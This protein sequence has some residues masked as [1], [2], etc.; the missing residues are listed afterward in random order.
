MNKTDIRRIKKAFKGSTQG[1]WNIRRHPQIG[2]FVERPKQSGEAYGVEILGE[3]DY[4]TKE[5]DMEFVVLAHKFMPEAL[6]II[7]ELVKACELAYI[8]L[9]N[10]NARLASKTLKNA[11]ANAENK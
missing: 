9:N 5:G 11:I 2:T 4:T 6:I 8:A 7:E 1:E 3:D 10:D